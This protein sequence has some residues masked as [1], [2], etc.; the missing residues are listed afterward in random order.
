MLFFH[1]QFYFSLIF[2]IQHFLEKYNYTT[3]LHKDG[4]KVTMLKPFSLGAQ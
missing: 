2:L 1:S 3:V 4:I